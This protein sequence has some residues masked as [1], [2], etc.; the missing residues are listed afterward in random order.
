MERLVAVVQQL[1]LARTLDRIVDIV[2][3][4]ARDLTGADGA[5][6]VLREH[7]PEGDV[8]FYVDEDAIG[9]LWKGRRFPAA[10]C[11][12]GWAMH[13][14]NAVIIED[15]FAD[16]RIP[17]SAYSPTFVK[18]LVMV[19]IRR[20]APIGAI[21]TYW[22]R[23]RRAT[24]EE[25]ALLQALA[26]CTSVAMENVEVYTELEQRIAQRTAE[27]AAAQ[28][29][30]EKRNA[31][32]VAL[33][34]RKEELSSLVVHDIKGPAGGLMLRSQVFLRRQDIPEHERRAWAGVYALSEAI[35]RMALNL[36]D[37][38]RSEDGAFKVMVED[39]PLAALLEEVSQVNQLAAEAR[40]QS[41]V[42]AIPKHPITLR[43]DREIIR[44]VLQN[45]LENALAHNAAL[46][47]VSL[48]ARPD[49]DGAVVIEIADEGPGVPP[50]QRDRIFDKYVQ[51]DGRG[52]VCP[53]RGLGLAFC[54]LAVEAHGGRI[55]VEDNTPRG[56]RFCVRLPLEACLP[57]PVPPAA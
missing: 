28:A 39:V 10:S 51:L 14:R 30:L 15:V 25:A 32:L 16:E 4:A 23:Q 37:I 8:C 31:A 56:S 26:D 12:S 24:L 6:F 13:H 18:S 41:L 7:G 43:V 19:P 50:E 42:V 3:V 21:G 46:G 2:R 40:G 20:A 54:R 52:L 33:G 29:E 34:R 17:A 9:P 36:L 1:S 27:L 44:R 47:T 35:A 55:W 5:T 11:I 38:S 49:G 22:A 53:G 48:Q 45:I 57:R